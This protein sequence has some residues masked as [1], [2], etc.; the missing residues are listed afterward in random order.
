MNKEDGVLKNSITSGT[1][2]TASNLVQKLLGFASFFILARLLKPED[3]GVVAIIFLIPKIIQ[4]ATELGFGTAAVQRQGDITEFLDPIWT[5]N[6]FKGVAITILIFV[7]APV[8]GILVNARQLATVIGMGGLL[9]LV[10]NL[11]NPGEIY[12]SK[13]LDFKKISIRNIIREVSY[14]VLAIFFAVYLRSYW[15]LI[16]ATFAS[17][18]IQTISTYFLHPY[19]PRLTLAFT[20]LRNLLHY[21]KW[22]IGQGWLD[23]AYNFVE[24]TAVARYTNL[25]NIGLYT[26][27]KNM[28]SVPTGFLNPVIS[29]VSFP[30]Y[31]KIKNEPEKVRDG[32]IKSLDI[33]FFFL[34]PI[35]ILIL[36]A[37]GAL[38]LILLGPTWLPMT[39]ALRILLV[40]Y[41][42]GSFND[43]SN[44]L[45]NAIGYP[46][47]EVLYNS[48]KIIVTI[49]LLLPLTLWGGISGAALAMLAGILPT[50]VLN[51]M[52]V[53]RYTGLTIKM[54]VSPGFVPLLSSFIVA[55]PF[56][57]AKEMFL[58][59]P[60][61]WLLFSGAVA[62]LLYGGLIVLWGALLKKGPYKTIQI[63]IKHSL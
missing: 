16:I 50:L 8:I 37:G 38:I 46:Q 3:F 43:M 40:F 34:I 1:W 39:A 30:A 17:Q 44:T 52:A 45:V 33:I 2:L 57:L 55:T 42:I 61:P 20:K 60:P 56:M 27:A 24:Q 21:S 62:A 36:Y 26:K 13:N 59:L 25:T 9:I 58:T 19:R 15:A 35:T 31:A 49:I 10:Q 7:I 28:A 41:L 29:L 4:S 12:F 47:K 22:V 11:A 54:L 18:L 6:V 23:Q 63:I 48:V 14:M 53:K 32:F 51:I 5:I